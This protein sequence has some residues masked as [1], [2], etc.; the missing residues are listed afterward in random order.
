TDQE[1]ILPYKVGLLIERS[2]PAFVARVIIDGSDAVQLL[3]REFNIRAV[4][5]AI[6]VMEAVGN[7]FTKQSILH[8]SFKC[9]KMN[10]TFGTIDMVIA[11]FTA[12]ATSFGMDIRLGIR[13]VIGYK[14]IL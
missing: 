2:D 4:C 13:R 11:G 12:P 14:F 8:L 3:S 5:C 7:L 9:N 6:A 1:G 10:P